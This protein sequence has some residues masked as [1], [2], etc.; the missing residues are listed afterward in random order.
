MRDQDRI[1]RE[2]VEPRAYRRPTGQVDLAETHI[3]LVFLTDDRSSRRKSLFVFHS[4]T[5]ARWRL[6]GKHASRNWRS[7]ADWRLRPT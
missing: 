3:S 5:T 1:R 7:I 6:A 4:W 2:L